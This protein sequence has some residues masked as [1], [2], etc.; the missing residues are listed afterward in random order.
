MDYA[1]GVVNIL[2]GVFFHALVNGRF[3]RTEA[4]REFWSGWRAQHPA[5]TQY[6]PPF[7]VAF[8][9]LRIGFGLLG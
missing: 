9:A 6:G 7:L 2:G 3:S 8:G 4:G 5:F 1:I